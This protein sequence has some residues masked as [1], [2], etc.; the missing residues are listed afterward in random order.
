MSAGALRDTVWQ[1]VAASQVEQFYRAIESLNLVSALRG[2]KQP[3]VPVKLMVTRV[4]AGACWSW[5]FTRITS[6]PANTTD[7]ASGAAVTLAD[8]LAEWLPDEFHPREAVAAPEKAGPSSSLEPSVYPKLYSPADPDAFTPGEDA[9]TG[10]LPTTSGHTER[11]GGSP[12]QDKYQHPAEAA[13]SPSRRSLPCSSRSL[14]GH[15]LVKVAGI[16]PPPDATLIW[17]HNH[18]KHFDH[19]LYVS[20]HLTEKQLPA[21]R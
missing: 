21:I 16:Q 18:L 11:L 4:P 1:H 17:L 10:D 7:S 9:Q 12:P 5:E 3:R 19:F 6:I 13:S 14:P 2:E 8:A 20:V 15:M